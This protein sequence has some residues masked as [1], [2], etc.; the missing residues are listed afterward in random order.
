MKD[1]L[2]YIISSIVEKSD[3]V[4]IEESETDGVTNYTISVAKEDMGRVIGKSGKVIRA[5]RNTMRIAAMKANKKIYIN[6]SENPL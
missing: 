4:D 1:L 2:K 3:E 5:I 6:L